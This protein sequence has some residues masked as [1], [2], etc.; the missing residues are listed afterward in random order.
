MP[1][2]GQGQE[3]PNDALIGPVPLIPC[4]IMEVFVKPLLVPQLNQ[5]YSTEPRYDSVS[6]P[7]MA[8]EISIAAAAACSPRQNNL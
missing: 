8:I 6:Y 2:Q 1:G 3:H 7:E 5:I 4:V